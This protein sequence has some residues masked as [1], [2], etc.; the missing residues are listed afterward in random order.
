MPRLRTAGK[1]QAILE[2]ATHV[3][4]QRPFHAV[5]IDDVAACARIGKGTIYRYFETKEDLY[6]AAVLFGMDRVAEALESGLSAEH[7]T[8]DR[9]E[10]I[11]REIL[12]YF[13]DRRYLIPMLQHDDE[14]PSRKDEILKRRQA[15]VRFAQETILEGIERRELR[16]ID[17]RIG[18]EL[19]L[20]MVRSA[21]LFRADGDRL[22]DLCRQIT[23]VFLEG[24]RREKA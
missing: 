10:R 23:N 6:F 3:F 20:G 19:F 22:P 2:A 11:A 16:G 24:V 8:S 15:I 21:N 1:E 18:A 7:T 5:L 17:A 4:A 12:E 9:L 14:D 13:W